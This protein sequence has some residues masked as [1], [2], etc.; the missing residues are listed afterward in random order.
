MDALLERGCGEGCPL[1]TAVAEQI[2]LEAECGQPWQCWQDARPVIGVGR[3]QFEIEQRA[4]LVADDEELDALDQLA[5]VDARA[6]ALGAER[7]ERLSTT[8]A[9]GSTS[10]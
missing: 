8:T 6:Q 4:M 5:A 2:A 9:E 7:S 1:E 10:S 3:M